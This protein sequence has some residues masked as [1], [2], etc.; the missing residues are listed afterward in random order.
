MINYQLPV[1]QS[2]GGGDYIAE[3]VWLSI[4]WFLEFG[5]LV[6]RQVNS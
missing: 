5:L 3:L 2:V 6:G 1:C 4:V